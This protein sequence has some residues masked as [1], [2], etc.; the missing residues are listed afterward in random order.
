M[1]KKRL[2]AAP[3][4]GFIRL[5][6]ERSRADIAADTLPHVYAEVAVKAKRRAFSRRRYRDGMPSAQLPRR[7]EL[8]S[9]QVGVPLTQLPIRQVPQVAL[10]VFLSHKMWWSAE[11]RGYPLLRI[12]RHGGKDARRALPE[13]FT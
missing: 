8:N 4:C 2:S 13:H 10:G 12:W 3:P 6:M 9:S 1:G 5:G 7:E 11:S